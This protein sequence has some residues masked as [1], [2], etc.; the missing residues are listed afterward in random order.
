[1]QQILHTVIPFK[2][3]D[4]NDASVIVTIPEHCVVLCGP[5]VIESVSHVA[6]HVNGQIRA[7]DI[8]RNN[9]TLLGMWPMIEPLVTYGNS[10]DIHGLYYQYQPFIYMNNV[11]HFRITGNGIIDGFGQSWWDIVTSTNQSLQNLLRAGR[12][13]LIQI[14]HSSFIEID[15]VTLTNSPFWTLHPVL[16]QYIHIH[17]I[18]ITAPL[19]AP[20]VDGIDPEYVT[21]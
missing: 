14:I 12:P 17:D 20:N 16:S 5:L 3:M 2:R 19:Y 8:A 11:S 10:R 4:S 15:S 18:T 1:M 7:W 9:Y 21:V 13:N 6:L